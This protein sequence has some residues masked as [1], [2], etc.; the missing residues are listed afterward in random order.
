ML[1]DSKMVKLL[2]VGHG[3]CICAAVPKTVLSLSPI[4]VARW[5]VA[6]SWKLCSLARPDWLEHMVAAACGGTQLL[7]GH[8]ACVMLCQHKLQGRVCE[9][10]P[11]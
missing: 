2:L 4:P 10:V 6:W 11:A 5:A 9:G 8:I 3:G 1:L 7:E